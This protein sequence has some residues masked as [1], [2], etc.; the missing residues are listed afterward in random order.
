MPLCMLL[1]KLTKRSVPS[2]VVPVNATLSASDPQ[3]AAQ[4]ARAAVAAGYRALKLKLAG[5]PKEDAAR[6]EAVR[7]AAP[8]AELRLDANGAWS[9]EEAGPR[10][11]ELLPHK[12]AYVEQPVPMDDLAALRAVRERRVVPIAAD[13]AARSPERARQ[14]MDVGACDVL[15]V[16]PMA[17]GG[18]D[19]AVEVLHEAWRRRVPVVVTTLLDG[20]VAREGALHVAAT[21]AEPR[22]ACGLALPDGHDQRIERGL[23]RVREA[24][25]LGLATRRR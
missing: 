22:P 20:P 6:V 10:L 15:I 12:P 8:S 5:S 23:L 7:A 3:E 21:L 1:A 24:P 25:G 16:K 14:V 18:P 2:A 9:L 11:A 4:A 17:L 19:H 13:E